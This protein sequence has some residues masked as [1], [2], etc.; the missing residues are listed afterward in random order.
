MRL[1]QALTTF[2]QVSIHDDPDAAARALDEVTDLPS[3]NLGTDVRAWALSTRAE[4]YASA[5]DAH[6][7]A[8]MLHQALDAW[9]DDIPAPAVVRAAGHAAMILGAPG[10]SATAAVLAGAA[11][12]GPLSGVVEFRFDRRTRTA[13]EE[14]IEH[15]RATLGSEVY[16]AEAARGAAMSSDELLHVLRHAVNAALA[17]PERD[18]PSST[19][20][21]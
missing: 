7:A 18:A 19:P 9:G 6:A 13:L 12:T 2:A 20:V 14:M 4:L 3:E 21:S 11:T 10:Q 8:V 1:A 5:G 16:D 15:L 17:A